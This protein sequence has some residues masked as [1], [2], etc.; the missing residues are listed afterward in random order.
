MADEPEHL[1][2]WNSELAS[3]VK[4]PEETS[5]RG[6]GRP[7]G[8]PN[9]GTKVNAPSGLK[10]ERKK[11]ELDPEAL[12]AAKKK[13]ANEIAKSLESTINDNVIQVVMSLGLPADMLYKPG[14]IPDSAPTNS[15]YS[16]LGQK[17]VMGPQQLE[18]IGRFIAEIEQTSIGEKLPAAGGN[19]PVPMIFYG[20]M[21]LAGILQYAQ[22]LAQVG[23]HIKQLQE[24]QARAVKLMEDQMKQQP[25][26]QE[27]QANG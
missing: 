26:T 8:S 1:R 10:P 3:Q 13:R 11:A 25:P 4:P 22:G 21:S 5:K 14:C 24:A 7:P 17:I 2:A 19:S 9:K 16:D 27:G 20:L 23:K 18:S 6:R 12:L 15:P